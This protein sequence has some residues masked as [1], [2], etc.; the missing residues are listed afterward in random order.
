MVHLY[1]SGR[2]VLKKVLLLS[3]FLSLSAC[4]FSSEIEESCPQALSINCEGLTEE[5]CNK[6]IKET[7]EEI[8]REGYPESRE[9]TEEEK[10]CLSSIITFY[11]KDESLMSKNEDFLK[12]RSYLSDEGGKVKNPEEWHKYLIRKLKDESEIVFTPEELAQLE[13]GELEEFRRREREF[14]GIIKGYL[15]KHKVPYE[16]SEYSRKI[17]PLS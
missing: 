3:F 2:S 17:E 8:C 14:K 9:Y 7:E 4:F 16:E 12:C 15:K 11:Y 10:L 1:L 13:T 6:L 5:E